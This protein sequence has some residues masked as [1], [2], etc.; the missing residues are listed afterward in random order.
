[1]PTHQSILRSLEAER[2]RANEYPKKMF[3]AVKYELKQIDPAVWNGV[4]MLTA[5]VFVDDVDAR[6][7]MRDVYRNYN[8]GSKAEN[9]QQ[10]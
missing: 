7:K 1:M 6:K 9:S 8:S 2:L 10:P 4:L 3:A 5:R